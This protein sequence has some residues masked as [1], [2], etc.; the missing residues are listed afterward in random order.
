VLSRFGLTIAAVLSLTVACFCQQAPNPPAPGNEPASPSGTVSTTPAAQD[1]KAAPAQTPEEIE[2]ELEKKEQS[3]HVFLVIPAFSATNRHHP[4]PLTPRGKFD[5]MLKTYTD[6]YIYALTAVQAGIGQASDSFLGYGQGMQ[7]YA[8]RYAANLTDAASS[9]FFCNFAYPVLFKQDPRYFRL[10][11]GSFGKRFFSAIS[12]VFVAHQDSGRQMFAFDNVLGAF[13][14]GTISNLYYP[15]SDRGAA[16]TASRA[17][18]SFLY[19][20]LGNFLVEFWPDID[21]HFRKNHHASGAPATAT[22]APVDAPTQ[23]TPR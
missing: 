12:Q 1:P 5:L 20:G 6:P 4:P 13:T 11:E 18:V 7:G 3:Q 22:P 14:S 23:D 21:H 8:K 10:G 17:S 9:N 2:R 16:L 19:G 15:K